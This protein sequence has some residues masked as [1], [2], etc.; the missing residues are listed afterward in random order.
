MEPAVTFPLNLAEEDPDPLNRNDTL[1]DINTETRVTID[2][3]KLKIIEFKKQLF[4]ELVNKDTDH[5][6]E[7]LGA[8]TTFHAIFL[9]SIAYWIGLL[10][11]RPVPAPTFDAG[12]TTKLFQILTKDIQSAISLN[13]D[14]RTLVYSLLF[15]FSTQHPFDLNIPPKKLDS[16]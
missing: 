7:S 15:S 8:M 6:A 13:S 5:S 16:E 4:S 3:L 11:G 12:R 1:D 2:K 10:D 14:A 9:Q